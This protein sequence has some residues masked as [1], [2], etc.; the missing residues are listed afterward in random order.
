MHST[1]RLKNR[2]TAMTT[3]SLLDVSVKR[4]LPLGHIDIRVLAILGQGVGVRPNL[5]RNAPLARTYL[6]YSSR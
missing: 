6:T 4:R 5:S 1:N 2:D 3:L